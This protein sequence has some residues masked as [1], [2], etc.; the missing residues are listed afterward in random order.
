MDGQGLA[1]PCVQTALLTDVLEYTS[2][3]QASF[4][5]ASSLGFAE[6]LGKS[7][8]LS[9]WPKSAA[10]HGLRPRPSCKSEAFATLAKG[11]AGGVIRLDGGPVDRF[12][13]LELGSKPSALDRLVPGDGRKPEPGRTRLAIVPFIIERLDRTPIVALSH[14]LNVQVSSVTRVAHRVR[15]QARRGIVQ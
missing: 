2:L 11:M 13:P 15:R 10:A 8:T 12:S 14:L 4:D 7:P 5:G 1:P 9:A 3:D 6:D